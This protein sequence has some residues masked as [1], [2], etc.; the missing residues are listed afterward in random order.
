MRIIFFGSSHFGEPSLRAL[1][2]GGFSIPLVVTQQDKPKNR[3]LHCEPT[4]IKSVA[5]ELGLEV[6]QPADINTCESVSFLGSFGADI[7]V[8]IAYGQILSA[9]VLALPRIK[10]LNVHAS[11]LPSYRGAAPINWCIAEGETKTGN[12]LIEMNEKMDAGPIILQSG[13]PILS[14]DTAVTLEKKLSEDAAE[15]LLAGIRSIEAGTASYIPQDTEKVSIAPKLKKQH[16]RIKWDRPAYATVNQAR[17]MQPWPGVFTS[18]KGK[19]L[20]VFELSAENY[21][22][23][24]EPAQEAGTIV[25]CDRDCI[26]VKTADGFLRI[27]SVQ[28]EG[29]RRMSIA[30]FLAGHSMRAGDIFD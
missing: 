30:D 13:I 16:G 12:T 8:V 18:Y 17:A 4:R 20:K 9:N 10:P 6:Y 21:I 27:R 15:L 5:R 29:K 14:V 2:A 23:T 7:F 25:S 26:L 1:A 24:Q 11:L 3:G 22:N 19:Y 28:P